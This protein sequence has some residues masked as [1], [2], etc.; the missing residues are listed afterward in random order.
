M[1]H[2]SLTLAV[3]LTGGPLKAQQVFSAGGAEHV[4]ADRSIA[5]TV[6][7]PVTITVSSPSATLTQGFQQP[8]ADIHTGVAEEATEGIRVY[9]NPTRH[10]LYVDHP[11]HADG[12]R[13]ELLD[14]SGARVL[15]GPIIGSLTELDMERF[16]SGG[17]VLWLHEAERPAIRSFK[18][19]VTR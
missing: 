8:W 5:F 12:D 3:L 13:Y 14:A 6:G 18:I 1:R 4:Q 17:Y 9:P 11:A 7:E 16:A 19:T 2:I 10:V 15:E